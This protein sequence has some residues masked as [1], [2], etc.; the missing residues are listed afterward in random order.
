MHGGTLGSLTAALE[1]GWELFGTQSVMLS[2]KTKLV[3]QCCQCALPNDWIN[4][5]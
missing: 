5:M 4:K 2:K 3:S 1:I